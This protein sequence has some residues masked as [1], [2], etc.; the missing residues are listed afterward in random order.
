MVSA[1]STSNSIAGLLSRDALA[2]LTAAENEDTEHCSGLHNGNRREEQPSD[3]L[4]THMTGN[5]VMSRECELNTIEE[6]NTYNAAELNSNGCTSLVDINLHEKTY[7]DEDNVETDD[8]MPDTQD[9]DFCGS[10]LSLI[11]T[12]S[13]DSAGGDSSGSSLFPAEEY[14]HVYMNTSALQESII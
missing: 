9:D 1:G 12:G 3:K 4:Y 11:S 5:N 14:R 8:E 2:D 13:D 6:F 10:K 7:F